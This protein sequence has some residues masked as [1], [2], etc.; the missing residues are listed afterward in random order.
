[1]GSYHRVLNLLICW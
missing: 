1:M